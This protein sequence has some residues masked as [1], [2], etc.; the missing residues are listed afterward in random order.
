[1]DTTYQHTMGRAE[2]LQETSENMLA[3]ARMLLS[4]YGLAAAAKKS[5]VFE[6][7]ARHALTLPIVAESKLV[8]SSADGAPDG[9]EDSDGR[10]DSK[11]S[12]AEV[13]TAP[14]GGLT[15]DDFIPADLEADT[16]Q[17]FKHSEK[18]K[19]LRFSRRRVSEFM[20][21]LVQKRLVPGPKAP[22][23]PFSQFFN[24]NIPA[25]VL[26]EEKRLWA[27]NVYAALRRFS[28]E[29]EFL[30]YFL[31]LKGS[32]SDIVVRDN[33]NICSELLKIFMTHYE[34]ADGQRHIKKSEFLVGLKEFLPNKSKQMR[35]D[36]VGTFP[37]GD[38]STLVNYEWLLFDDLYILSPLVYALRLQHLEEAVSLSSRL[39][40]LVRSVGDPKAGT[41]SFEEIEDAFK[42]DA[43]FGLIVPADVARAFDCLDPEHL[44]S[45]TTQNIESFLAVLNQG[46]I[47]HTLFFPLLPEGDDADLSGPDDGP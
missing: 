3:R 33:K 12:Q 13:A 39:D 17:I 23:K 15:D 4:A 40:A 26:Q 28:A 10:K 27:I 20:D 47:F 44:T 9:E 29:P 16:P 37:A 36:L 2:H 41:V 46:D 45:E 35:T 1:V 31:L 43:E 22:S 18:L 6:E 21:S 30:A 24:E 25:E 32:I 7:H 19:N 34:A 11:E 14:S 8:S 5:K 42:E 38:A